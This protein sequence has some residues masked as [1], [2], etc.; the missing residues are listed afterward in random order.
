MNKLSQVLQD[1]GLTEWEKVGFSPESLMVRARNIER[2]R[3]QVQAK[4]IYRTHR[5]GTDFVDLNGELD[6]S[7]NEQAA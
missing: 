1:N 7:N 5:G 4:S 6:Y 2:L 3:A